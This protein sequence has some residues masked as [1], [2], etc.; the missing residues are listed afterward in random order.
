MSWL[1]ASD[2]YKYDIH[3][4]INRIRKGRLTTKVARAGQILLCHYLRMFDARSPLRNIYLLTMDIAWSMG[5]I[6]EYIENDFV[7]VVADTVYILS[8]HTLTSG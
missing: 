8:L 2:D 7:C 6:F 1:H 5:H 3:E 4:L